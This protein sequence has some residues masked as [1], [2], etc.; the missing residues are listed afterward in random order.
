MPRSDT[1]L[2]TQLDKVVS[3]PSVSSANTALDMSN[4]A[5]IDYLANQ[6]EA[7]GFSC[8]V[9]PCPSADSKLNLIATLGTGPGGLVLAGHTDTVPLNEE[10]WSMDPFRLSERDGKLF[11]LGITDMKGFF[12]IVMEAVRPLLDAEFKEPLIVL[13]T[14]D[15]E[16]SMQGARTLAE[17]GRPRARAAIIGEPT[18]LQAVRSHKGIMMDVVRLLGK[19]GHSSDPSLGNNA[20]DAMHLVISDLIEFRNELKQR[21]RNELFKIPYPTL[22]L[23][24]IHGGDNPNRICGHCN[25][26][27][28]IRLMPGMHIATVRQEISQRIEAIVEPLGIQYELVPIFTGVPAFFAEEN[29]A[30]LKTAEQLTGHAGINVAFGTEGPFL[31]KLGMDTIIMGPGSIDQAHQPDEYMSMAMIN[32]CIEI[33][34]NIITKYCL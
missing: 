1:A 20:L 27:F 32:P 29:S 28:D 25:L 16:T 5:V 31:Q 19:S 26:E 15:E 13:A 9:V 21:Y 23:G 30:L 8:E 7:M 2:L 3:L 10:L 17:L 6:F 12:P 24:S 34:R 11:G 18:G 14:A 22:N 33:L 4:K